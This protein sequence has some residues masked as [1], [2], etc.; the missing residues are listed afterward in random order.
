MPPLWRN[1]S[2]MLL[3]SGQTISS[4]GSSISGIVFPLLILALTHSPTA[5]GIAGALGTIPY[6]IFSLPVGAL[7]DRWDRKLVM[8]LCDAGRAI[9]L[10]SVPVALAFNALTIWQ[11]YINAFVEGTLFVFFNIAEVASL[12]RVVDKQQLPA[13]A[14]QN[15]AA[16][17][18][19]IL[20]GPQLG[21]IIYQSLGRAIPFVFDAVSYVVSVIS[22][23]FIKIPFQDERVAADRHLREEIREGVAWLWHQPLVRFMAFLTG[24]L[25][26]VNSA[27]FLVVIVVAKNFGASDASI[28]TIFTIG[29]IGGIGGALIGGRI[30]R[31]FRFGQV[32]IATVWVDVLL[33]PLYAVAPHVLV[34][35]LITAFFFLVGPIYNV[36]QFS[37]RISIIPDALQGRVNS[38]FR[39][40]A[41]GFQPLGSF[42]AGVL[43]DNVGTGLTIAFFSVCLL[44]IGL[45]T[46][47]NRPLREA[48]PI[49]GQA[50]A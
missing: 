17:N 9:S 10:A 15:E 42:I 45:L 38:S 27:I 47:F 2:Y 24:G 33:V 12:G 28:G 49:H 39:L 4:L 43:L 50:A 34:L 8:M 20:I 31:R 6:L 41:F 46:A 1:R 35:G 26:F 5:A 25:N 37:Y 40:L 11:L 30:Q 22:L 18:I 48:A 14:A 23:S 16:G 3:W 32:I 19:S 36:V 21:T 7:I 13:A 44:V 29:A